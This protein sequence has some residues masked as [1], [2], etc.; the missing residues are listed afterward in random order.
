MILIL[1]SV[2][3]LIGMGI[4]VLIQQG[5]RGIPVGDNPGPT[6][7]SAPMILGAIALL[8][9]SY[10]MKLEVWIDQAGIHYRFFPMIVKERLVSFSEIKKYEI[11]KYSPIADYGG[12]GTKKS[13]RWGKAYNVSGNI[14]LQLYLNNGRKVLFGTQKPQAM[15]H[16]IDAA[17]KET[18]NNK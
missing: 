2:A 6:W 7:I 8:W 11:R 10:V 14:G 13:F 17:I 9:M 3:P 12:W 5:L 1:A 18:Q 4:L 15:L 16:A